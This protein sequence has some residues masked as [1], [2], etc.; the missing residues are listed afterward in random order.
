MRIVSFFLYSLAVFPVIAL[1]QKSSVLDDPLALIDSFQSDAIEG[2]IQTLKSLDTLGAD[3][4]VDQSTV[5]YLVYTM[6]A[7]EASASRVQ[8]AQ[9]YLLNHNNMALRETGLNYIIDAAIEEID[10]LDMDSAKSQLVNEL[11]GLSGTGQEYYAYAGKVSRA[12]VILGDERGLDVFL[13][14]SKTIKNYS[15]KDGWSA[16]SPPEKLDELSQ[17]YREKFGQSQFNEWDFFWSRFYELAKERRKQGKL[18]AASDPLINLDSV[19]DGTFEP[20]RAV[21]VQS[22]VTGAD[23]EVSPKNPTAETPSTPPESEIEGDTQESTA[24]KPATEEPDEVV[25]AEP[26]EEPTEQSSNWWL[27]LIGLLVV[28]GGLAVVVRR[29]S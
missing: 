25:N 21:E 3:Q 2:K 8:I 23:A 1:A 18:L 16:D 6:L 27:W 20:K 19:L 29:K 28:L 4:A 24:P 14:N 13:T 22:V 15:R 9:L 5:D 11:E 10:T 26:T 12:L 7:Q 17:Q